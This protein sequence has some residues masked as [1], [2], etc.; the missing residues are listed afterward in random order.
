MLTTQ[1]FSSAPYPGLRPFEAE[2]CDIFFGREK[3]TDDL[4]AKLQRNRFL[5]VVGPSGCGKSSLVRAGLIAALETGFMSD[6]GARWRVAR[7]RPGDRPMLR[8]AES[9]LTP[10]LLGPERGG[11][12]DAALFLEAALLRGPLG[13]LEIASESGLCNDA[14]LLVLVD[15]FEEIF[16]FRAQGNPDEA[17]AFVALL[18]ATAAQTTLPIYIIITMRSDFLGDCSLFR[19]L[20][21]SI[22]RSAYLIPR[23]TREECGSAITGPARV[24]GG[25]IDPALVNRLLNDFGPD[26][27]QLPL[28]QHALMRMWFRR[29][30]AAPVDP[31]QRTV[32]TP[33]D[34]ETLGGLPRALSD[35]ADE[36]MAELDAGD[37]RIAKVLFQ[38]LTERGS[39]KRDTRAPARL[40]DIARVAGVEES[41]VARVVNEFRR[42]GRCFV[43]PLEGPLEGDTLLDIGH[44]SLIRQWKQLSS[45]VD[46]EAESAVMYI[47]LRDTAR[48]WDAG[49]AG[50]WS[51]PDLARAVQW[52]ER[53]APNEPWAAR[54]GQPGDFQVA[55]RF[56]AAS[57]AEHHR[58]E[59]DAR[60]ARERALRHA[61]RLALVLGTI[62]IAILA[63]FVGYWY[64]WVR[65]YAAHYAAF[66]KV[67]GVPSGIGRLTS[68]QVRHRPSSLRIVRSGRLGLVR[69][70]ESVDS[71]G[72]LSPRHNVGTYLSESRG[73][74]QRRE[75]RWEFVYDA[76]DR[77]AYE[78]AY[79][80]S[81]RRAWTFIYAPT[82]EAEERV[83]LAHFLDGDGYPRQT[84][85]YGGG[86]VRIDYDANGHEAMFSYRNA[87]GEPRAGLDRAFG[88]RQKFDEQGRLIE[89]VSVGPDGKPMIDEAGNAGLAFTLDRLGNPVELVA[90]DAMGAVTTVR[91]GWSRSRM[92]YD[93]YGNIIELTF[94]DERGGPTVHKNGHHRMARTLDDRGNTVEERYYDVD[95]R[96]TLA[97]G[98]HVLRF[99]YDAR[100]N[101]VEEKCL[102]VRDEPTANE[103]GVAVTRLKYDEAGNA[104][105]IAFFGAS[106]QRVYGFQ[107]YSR[108]TSRFDARGNRLESAYFGT[109][110]QPVPTRQGYSRDTVEYDAH[111]NEIARSFFGTDGKPMVIS[112]DREDRVDVERQA[113]PLSYARLERKYDENGNLVHEAYF[114]PYGRPMTGPEGY[115]SW[116][117]TYDL[118]GNRREVAYFGLR[119]ERVLSVDGYAGWRPQYDPLGRRTKV[120][121]FGVRS[122]P[123]ALKDGTAGWTSTY[124]AHGNE[125][126]RTYFGLDGKPA[127]CADGYAMERTQYDRRG[128]AVAIDY[129]GVDRRPMLRPWNASRPQD[130][131]YARFTLAH[132]SRNR[133][134]ERAF[135]GL[136]GQ[137]VR[138]PEGWSRVVS[139]FDLRGTDPVELAFFDI[140]DRP[141]V[142]ENGYHRVKRR[143]DA[144]GRVVEATYYGP[145]GVPMAT[146]EGYAK[147]V[148]E[149]DSYG[150]LAGQALFG[151]DGSPTFIAGVHR[152]TNQYDERGHLIEYRYF[153][154]RNERVRL[155]GTLQHATRY[156][157]DARG[158]TIEVAHFDVNDKPTGGPDPSR[159][160]ICTRWTGTYD[161]DGR[162]LNSKC[163]TAPQATRP[164]GR[165]GANGNTSAPH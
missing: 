127:L 139:R 90:T 66:S 103:Q 52:R 100:D 119:G 114:D 158:N 33:A 140:D 49:Q 68:D 51:N 162:L 132:D 9:L 13:L 3:Q 154:A 70:M 126:E 145:D 111:D 97:S 109:N 94:F 134:V 5:A 6:A 30:T 64:F 26:P 46:E 160:R 37:Q 128:Q 22:N 115:A 15:Q 124:D 164:G 81:G 40:A 104:V 147:L 23:L 44:E 82:N 74:P 146:K 117:A 152:F 156:A 29:T 31:L 56:L 38:R 149:Y 79:D 7:M 125:I 28:L 71:R 95:G 101:A 8:L 53:A 131:G 153:G 92:K 10:S 50:L 34:Y 93:A 58:R 27:D 102:G 150:R 118:S 20:P 151:S 110:D 24:F 138:R 67:D 96:A 98:C 19:D 142:N 107:G 32:L 165:A 141:A 12:A 88:R 41:A 116:T 16:R 75:V 1:A 148:N 18:L 161:S 157:Y 135:F 78:A 121:Y 77:V 63:A 86:Y 69:R 60:R 143:L 106:G 130:G 21:E 89:M 87:L 61:R 137:R 45:W 108:M 133:V 155:S 112:D 43:T 65:E 62:V 144:Y 159:T 73:V 163:E 84:Q 4:L 36:V 59:E 48:L 72:E 57:E 17:E 120:E 42:A 122:E 123:V 85:E 76:R 105:D 11:R 35:H 113:A 136:D 55:M 39:G 91:D 129:F 99:R 54:Y 83:R 47:R 80:M 25:E 14:N 2:E